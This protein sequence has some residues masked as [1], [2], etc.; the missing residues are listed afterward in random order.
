MP[1]LQRT[2]SMPIGA[3]VD[4]RHAVVARARRQT[5]APASP[6]PSIAAAN[7]R[8]SAGAQAA[9]RASHSGAIDDVDA[10]PR[11]RSPRTLRA[12]LRP[13]RCALRVGRR[14]HVEREAH[15]AGNDVHR[16]GQRLDACRRSRRH[17]GVACATPRSRARI[18]RPPPARRGAVASARCPHG[19]PCPPT[20]TTKRL[21]PL[22]AVTTP[23]GKPVALRAPDPA[24]CAA[25]RRRARRRAGAPRRAIA[26]GSSPKPRER[27]AHRRCPSASTA[28]E[29]RFASNVPATARLPSSVAPKRTPSSSAKPDD[30]DGERQPRALAIERR[31]AFDRRNDAE[32]AVVLAG[33]AHGVEMR[34]EHQARQH[35]RRVAF[36][37]A[38]AVAD[39]I[40]ARRH[41]G[42]AHPAQHQRVDRAL[43]RRQEDA[44]EAVGLLRMR[45]QR[46]T[47]IVDPL[48][49]DRHE[50]LV[51]L[52]A[53]AGC[54]SGGEIAA[55]ASRRRRACLPSGRRARTSR[56]TRAARTPARRSATIR[57]RG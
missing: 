25:R 1:P 33:V 47:A 50:R 8:C 41:A 19:R 7:W 5:R 23:T 54:A 9:V 42:V 43:L 30:L 46:L 57:T 14:A 51:A 52:C 37:A 2:N 10:A 40:E 16:A 38:D 20:S 22:I 21:P 3:I 53:N 12:S 49:V 15:V 45:G 26:T 11:A 55:C 6:R 13:P 18:R 34:A 36:V 35:R 17:R 31:D 28:I 27:V 39:R 48:R 29:Q 32:H 4:D 44:R 24:R 56:E